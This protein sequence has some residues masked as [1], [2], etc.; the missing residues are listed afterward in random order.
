MNKSTLATILGVAGLSLL[1]KASGST[2]KL[3]K[4]RLGTIWFRITPSFSLDED[5]KVDEWE[6]PDAGVNSF[7]FILKEF[8][9][10]N[11]KYGAMSDDQILQQND[12]ELDEDGYIEGDESAILRELLDNHF[13]CAYAIEE[14]WYGIYNIESDV[15]KTLKRN[16]TGFLKVE[17]F[18]G[19]S[20][21]LEVNVIDIV[22]SR[23]TQPPVKFHTFEDLINFVKSDIVGSIKTISSVLEQQI[24]E[25]DQI[26]VEVNFS[27]EAIEPSNKLWLSAILGNTSELRKF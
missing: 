3:P 22:N 4:N 9:D 1:K 8:V 24:Y 15:I 6:E 17:S 27:I 16:S 2:S 11:N 13:N 7:Y 18:G 23:N 12:V 26:D 25:W 14:E 20:V 5:D 10:W 19:S 21:F